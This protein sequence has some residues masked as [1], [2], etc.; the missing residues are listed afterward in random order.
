MPSLR[1]PAY[2]AH[3]QG[4]DGMRDLPGDRA[5]REGRS[6]ARDSTAMTYAL[7]LTCMSCG[8]AMKM[9]NSGGHVLVVCKG[10]KDSEACG[11]SE[12]VS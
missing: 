11:F 7:K 9:V 4:G 8:G 5:Q 6:R 1:F 3:P 2:G 12:V 10:T